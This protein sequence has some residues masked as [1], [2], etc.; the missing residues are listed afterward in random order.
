MRSTR[1]RRSNLGTSVA[2]PDMVMLHQLQLPHQ[3]CD[4]DEATRLHGRGRYQGLGWML[5]PGI[6]KNHA[7]MW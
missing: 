2:S 6:T 1:E 4:A 3:V 5:Q 7:R